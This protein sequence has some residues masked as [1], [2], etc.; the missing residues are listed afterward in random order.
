MYIE[1]HFYVTTFVLHMVLIVAGMDRS[2]MQQVI[3]H[4]IRR[5]LNVW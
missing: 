1:V 2:Q 5:L 4:A 3:L